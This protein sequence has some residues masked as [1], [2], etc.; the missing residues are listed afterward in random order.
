MVE[1]AAVFLTT[2]RRYNKRHRV[3]L[4]AHTEQGFAQF[5]CTISHQRPSVVCGRASL[6]LTSINININP[7]TVR[8]LF[9]CASPVSAVIFSSSEPDSSTDPPQHQIVAHAGDIFCVIPIPP[10]PSLSLSRCRL[11]TCTPVVSTAAFMFS[12]RKPDNFIA[13]HCITLE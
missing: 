4:C 1:G 13:I 2:E 9:A 5:W 3:P 8:S 10:S 7:L 6:G 11:F 12:S